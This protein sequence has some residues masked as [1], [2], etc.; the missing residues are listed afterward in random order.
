[1][2]KVHHFLLAA[3]I[4]CAALSTR[5]QT[6]LT[7]YFPANAKAVVDINLP[8]LSSKMSWDEIKQLDWFAEALKDA[9]QEIQGFL[10]DPDETGINFKSSLY[11]AILPEKEDKTKNLTVIYGLINDTAK[12]SAIFN[13]TAASKKV[14]PLGNMR[15]WID[16]S[17]ALVWNN[18]AFAMVLPSK[19]KSGEVTANKTSTADIQK[20]ATEIA[21]RAKTLLS[22]AAQSLAKKDEFIALTQQ[23][24]D[25][26][27]WMNRTEPKPV[28]KDNPA[29]ALLNKMNLGLFQQGNY[30]TG[31]VMFENGKAVVRTK[32]YLNKSLDSLYKLYPGKPINSAL[33]KKLPAGQPIALMSFNLSPDMARAMVKLMGA[34]KMMDSLTKKSP[35]NLKDIAEGLN[36]DLTM[37][38]IQSN[39]I[40]DH[41]SISKAF[42][43]IQVILAASVKNKSKLEPLAAMAQ[44]QNEKKETGEKKPGPLGNFKPAIL[45]NNDY[46][47]VSTSS[48]VAEKFMAA[49]ENQQL[50]QDIQPYINSTSLF[51]LDL[52]TILAFARQMNKKA[53]DMGDT[54][55]LMNTFDKV[56]LYGNGYANGSTSA[57]GELQL[58]DKNQ[59]SLKQLMK[60]MDLG[61]KMAARNKL[62]K[63]EE[64][65]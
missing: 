62:N 8:S 51:S 36:G 60:L 7:A 3:I 57:T 47:V 48:F 43:G 27:F 2:K 14:R 46:L 25:I 41:D 30:M 1:M 45:L 61:Y 11:V 56:V 5:A 6:N 44:K 19:K 53:K 9:P 33:L 35:V 63:S 64:R 12:F 10:E 40:D 18:N 55:E 24:G 22:P 58:S 37:A 42:N 29:N 49:S 23:D 32:N 39:D 31:T 28:A 50:M 38:V 17:D 34:E 65:Q 13:Q 59:N 26:R 20:Q 54:E 4:L 15:V 52:K 16:K 21:N